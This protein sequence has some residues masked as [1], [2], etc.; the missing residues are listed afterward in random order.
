MFFI[1]SMIDN[2]EYD[3]AQEQLDILEELEENIAS[4]PTFLFVKASFMRHQLSQKPEATNL[5]FRA[6]KLQMESVELMT[7]GVDYF[8]SLNPDFLL[9]LA[10]EYFHHSP[11]NSPHLLQELIAI[12]SSVV[13]ACPGLLPALY[14]L[15]NVYLMVGDLR[16]ASTTLHHVIDHV[17]PTFIEAYLLMA[18]IGI[19]QNNPSLAAQYLELGLSYN[20]QVYLY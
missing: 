15:A 19:Q 2:G 17:D 7:F 5:L 14:R 10:E 11:E 13:E 9:S 6:Y 1:H 20:F 3:D 16:A 4:T 18:R 8:S 12:L